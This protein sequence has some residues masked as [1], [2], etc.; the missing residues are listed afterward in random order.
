M[1]GR[2][3]D[4]LCRQRR[5]KT[6]PANVI[7]QGFVRQRSRGVAYMAIRRVICP[8]PAVPIEVAMATAWPPLWPPPIMAL[9]PSL[10]L[11]FSMMSNKVARVA[12]GFRGHSRVLYGSGKLWPPWPPQDKA[13]V[14]NIL[15]VPMM[16]TDGHPMATGLC[17]DFNGLLDFV[18]SLFLD[19][20][21][22]YPHRALFGAGKADVGARRLGDP[23]IGAFQPGEKLRPGAPFPIGAG[24]NVIETAM[25]ARHQ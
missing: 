22:R 8:P 9:T 4:F 7:R 12:T 13:S 2:T 10:F 11:F 20:L 23:P 24:K 15:A 1:P 17:Q 16:A 18:V 25:P 21:E 5:L 19:Y 6:A 3:R 14:I